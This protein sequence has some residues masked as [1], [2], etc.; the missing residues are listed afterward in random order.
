M[1]TYPFSPPI[2]LVEEGKW[3]L[4]VFSF[5]ATN[6]VFII[7]D[8]NISFSIST[9]GHWSSRGDAA[10]INKLQKLLQLIPQN[11]NELHVEEVRKRG[12]QVENGDK[13]YKESHL[14]THKNEIIKA[15]KLQNKTMFKTFF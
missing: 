14:D 6:S 5:E 13:E 10:F 15:L 1:E 4:G 7:T 2:N 9:P 8:G 12:N 11:D 3:L